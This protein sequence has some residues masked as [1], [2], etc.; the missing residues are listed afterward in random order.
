MRYDPIW[1][2]W[3]A[4][5]PFFV[6]IL[7]SWS[8]FLGNKYRRSYRI[9]SPLLFLFW[10]L[11]GSLVLI[12]S[13]YGS[14]LGLQP[15]FSFIHSLHLYF[16]FVSVVDR[17]VPPSSRTRISFD[18]WPSTSILGL[19]L[20]LNCLILLISILRFWCVEPRWSVWSSRHRIRRFHQSFVY[21]PFSLF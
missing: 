6:C 9:H 19:S 12:Q 8:S 11:S 17:F 14:S 1:K 4:R 21:I 3:I 2:A 13:V 5:Q 16:S 18:L 20:V 7:G 15:L 10:V